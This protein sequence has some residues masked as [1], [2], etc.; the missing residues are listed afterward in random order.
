MSPKPKKSKQ[1]RPTKTTQKKGGAAKQ[2][3]GRKIVYPTPTTKLCIGDLA[4]TV[5]QAK[6]LLGWEEETDKNKFGAEYVR[7]LT[8]LYPKKVRCTNNVT[9]RPLYKS[10]L[11]SLKQEIL[12]RKWHY[13][14]EP[15]IIGRTGLVLNGQH[16]LLALILAALEVVERPDKWA[17]YWTTE[18]TLEKVIAFG[19]CE[20]DSVVNTM[21]TCK[22][23]SLADVIYRSAYFAD[24]A[25]KDRRIASRMASFAIKLA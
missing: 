14:G 22:P 17:E 4:I 15:V 7:T 16:T 2:A 1:P 21:D 13:N 9:N 18:P 11:D 20:D 8:K 5:G 6:E 10:V 25:E 3:E 19:V 23:R 24:V 12:R